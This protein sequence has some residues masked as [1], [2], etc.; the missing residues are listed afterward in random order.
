MIDERISVAEH[1]EHYGNEEVVLLDR[2][3]DV[4]GY[5]GHSRAQWH[6][7]VCVGQKGASAVRCVMDEVL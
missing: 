1:A 5:S 6:A 2:E 3:R 7:R 4:T